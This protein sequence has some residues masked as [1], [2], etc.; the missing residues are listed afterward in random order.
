MKKTDALIGALKTGVALLALTG[1][2]VLTLNGCAV[3]P[4]Y[5]QPAPP[6]TDAY[7]PEK[8]LP[9]TA[10]ANVPGGAAQRFV[11]GRDIPGQWWTLFKS[12]ELDALIVQALN[13]NPDLAA[14]Q[15]ALRAARE[16]VLAGQGAYYPS[17]GIGANGQRQQ[18]SPVGSGFNGPTNVYNLYN[19]SVSVSYSPDVFGRVQRSVEGLQAQAEIAQLQLEATYLALTA[20]VVT[21][22][23][24]EASVRG[25]IVA[26]EEIIKLQRNQVGLLRQQFELGGVSRV[27]VLAQEANL[28]QTQATL[29][30]LQKALA[31]TRNQLLALIGNF[32]ADDVASK[33]DLAKLTLPTDLPVSLPS[34]LVRQR[35]DIRAAEARLKQAT[36]DIGV[37]TA[38]LY[39]QFNITADVATV[40]LTLAKLFSPGSIIWSFAGSVAQAIFKGGQLE[41]QK[42]ATEALFDQALAQYKGTLLGAF[43]DVANS[44]RA[45]QADAD[46]L[47]AQDAAV[48]AAAA[49]LNISRAQFQ[50]GAT[51]YLSLLNAQQVYL[52]ARVNLVRAQAQ[53]LADTAALF[54]AMGGGWWNRQDVGAP[55]SPAAQ[56]KQ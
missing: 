15:A 20:N 17:I 5:K 29:P 24:A 49:S 47:K 31:Q 25:Q 43:Q 45:I 7:T 48:R 1:C 12:P 10:S 22:V 38:N 3:G 39:P 35:P 42:K 23:I 14:A 44:L 2:A 11:L 4:D 32:P 19:A 37:A 52:N 27:D 53:R 21:T 33:F 46:A 26:T 54:Q 41:H 16:N 56:G 18:V 9:D 30:P 36:A 55:T 6:A 13:N 28:A 40:A 34:E 51:T 8:T 50:T